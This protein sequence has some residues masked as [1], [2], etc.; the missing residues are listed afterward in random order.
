[1]NFKPPQILLWDS[2]ALNCQRSGF[3]ALSCFLSSRKLHLFYLFEFPHLPRARSF[4]ALPLL[5]PAPPAAFMYQFA[6][7]VHRMSR[8]G[9][10]CAAKKHQFNDAPA[11]GWYDSRLPSAVYRKEQLLLVEHMNVCLS[12]CVP[13]GMS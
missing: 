13:Q 5:P 4:M 9:N 6:A 10:K 11:L 2:G 7:N 12:L 3:D 8:Q 1:M